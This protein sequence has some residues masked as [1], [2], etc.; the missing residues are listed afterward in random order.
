M[1]EVLVDGQPVSG[2]DASNTAVR[3]RLEKQADLADVGMYIY[4]QTYL[5]MY[6]RL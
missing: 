5:C 2:F 3:V 6:G 4:I 1:Y